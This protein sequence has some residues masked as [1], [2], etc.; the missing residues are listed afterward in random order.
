MV[1]CKQCKSEVELCP[2]FVDPIEAAKVEVFDAKIET[3]AYSAPE[4]T[5]EIA[6]KSGQVWQLFGVPPA[7]YGELR[8]TTISS[9]LKFIARR[10]KSA[11]VKTGLH[12]IKVPESETCWKCK[13]VMTV[14]HRIDS[15]FDINIRV[16][17]EC[18]GCNHTEWR[19]Y[20]NGLVREKKGRWH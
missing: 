18:A 20:G 11:P 8:D 15:R 10:Y 19:Q 16:L 2:H 9:F 13:T 5:L 4:R 1:F 12:A 7:I 14:R 6:F 3:L 17:W